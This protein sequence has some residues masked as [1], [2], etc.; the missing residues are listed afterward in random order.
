MTLISLME[1]LR[2]WTTFLAATD[3]HLAAII[4]EAWPQPPGFDEA[5][6]TAMGSPRSQAAAAFVEALAAID[7]RCESDEAIAPAR[8][9]PAPTSVPGGDEVSNR[10]EPEIIPPAKKRGRP[11]ASDGAS[12]ARRLLQQELRNGPRRGEHIERAAQA[13]AISKPLLLTAADQL[14]V[15]SKRGEWRLPG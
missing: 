7:D 1:V 12:R 9:A 6:A 4:R 13:A 11:P 5:L 15:R 10:R 14:G 3:P 8:P 2:N